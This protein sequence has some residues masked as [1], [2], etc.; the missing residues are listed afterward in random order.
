MACCT[1]FYIKTRWVQMFSTSNLSFGILATVLT[2]FP[3]IGRIFVQF[4]GHSGKDHA[5]NPGV[6]IDRESN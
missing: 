6:L 5:M 4:S 2:T 1:Y 3:Y